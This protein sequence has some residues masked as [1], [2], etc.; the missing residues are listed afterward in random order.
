MDEYLKAFT[1]GNA[2]ILTNVC[3]LPLYP[4]LFVMFANRGDDSRQPRATKWMGVLV[5]AGIITVM[6]AIGFV[7]HQLGQ[8][9]ADILDWLLPSMYALV[10]ILGLSM[11]AGWNPFARLA[12]TEAP[13]MR[14]PAASAY[15][16]G[17]MLG[18]MTLPCTGPLIVSA[19]VLG[20]VSGTGALADSLVYFLCFAIGFGWPL[21]A[22]PLLATP[23]QRQI[24][25][26]LGVHHRAV[27][28]LSGILLIVIAVVGFRSDVLP[29]R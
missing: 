28:V 20:G 8:A 12:T 1:L 19:F 21:A 5:L 11:L 25:G 27:A 16:Y 17:M 3:M 6:L 24:T 22:L 15:I 18:P 2:A 10:A 9:V 4:G 7:L 13:V 23:V 29:S 26:F 14:S